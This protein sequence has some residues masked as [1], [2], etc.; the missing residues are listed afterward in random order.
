MLFLIYSIGIAVAALSAILFKKTLFRS[1]DIPFVMELPPYRMPTLRS[2]TTHMWDKAV[3]Y[4]K[5]MS[6]IILI[7]SIII[8]ALGHFPLEINFSEDYDS[9]ISTIT[10]NTD[11]MLSNNNFSGEIKN[12][13]TQNREHLIRSI[14]IKKEAERQEKSYIGRIGYFFEPV[15][16][17]LG[18]DWRMG[19][20][21]ITGLAAKE[22]V[23]SSMG[24]LFNI[25]SKSNEGMSALA[26]KLKDQKVIHGPR[27]GENLF[28]PIVAFTFIIFI[29]IY[30]PCIATV[31]A[32]RKETGS[33]K[34]PLFSMLYSTGAAWVL[35]FIVYQVG[36]LFQ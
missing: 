33:F 3:Q 1:S 6:G 21:I 4:L 8:W 23:V 32:M 24:V 2:A 5:K 11:V 28:T 12:S 26:E 18:F 31:A 19:I 34:W 29:L 15:I 30:F 27:K 13:I 14:E 20:S 25:D 36:S 17:P 16:A 7:S 10:T 35:S 22:I 9:Q